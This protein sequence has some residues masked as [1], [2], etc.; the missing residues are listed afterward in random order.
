MQCWARAGKGGFS[1]ASWARTCRRMVRDLGPCAHGAPRSVRGALEVVEA[2][3]A[4]RR[5]ASAGAAPAL[6]EVEQCFLRPGPGAKRTP[7]DKSVF[8]GG[9]EAHGHGVVVAVARRGS[10]RTYSRSPDSVGPT[11]PRRASRRPHALIK[12]MAHR[13]G[14]AQANL[15]IE[16]VEDWFGAKIA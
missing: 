8:D 12:V 13:L 4:Q 6:E 11:R 15:H 7:G 14:S 3:M 5:A 9:A 16:R 2:G 10:R 1:L